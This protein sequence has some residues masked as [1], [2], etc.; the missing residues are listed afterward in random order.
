ME[1]T[2]NIQMSAYVNLRCHLGIVQVS[3]GCCSR[4]WGPA[5]EAQGP[6]LET[7]ICATEASVPRDVSVEERPISTLCTYSGHIIIDHK[8]GIWKYLAAIEVMQ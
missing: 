7:A 2:R 3:F 8:S 4:V 5:L 1:S 6:R